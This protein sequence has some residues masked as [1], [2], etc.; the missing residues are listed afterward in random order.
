MQYQYGGDNSQHAIST[1]CRQLPMFNFNTH[2]NT[3][4]TGF[5]NDIC[6]KTFYPIE[7]QPK[8]CKN[9]PH[10]FSG[11]FAAT[12]LQSTMIGGKYNGP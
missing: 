10:C 11:S 3:T 5:G 7:N 2:I 12:S 8:I 9:I 6:T 1:L 4:N